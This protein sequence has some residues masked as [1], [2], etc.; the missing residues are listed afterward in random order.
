MSAVCKCSN[1]HVFNSRVV[2]DSPEINYLE[3]EE[4]DCPE[5]HAE[6]DVVDIEWDR[7]DDDAI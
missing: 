4:P 3:V 2:E 1:G 5:C 7:W 6:F